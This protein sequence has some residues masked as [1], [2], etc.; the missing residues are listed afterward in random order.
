[1]KTMTNQHLLT[2]YSARQNFALCLTHTL[3]WEY[4]ASF[5]Y[6]DKDY[7]ANTMTY[8]YLSDFWKASETFISLFYVMLCFFNLFLGDRDLFGPAEQV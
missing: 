8:Y 5:N 2:V 6:Q 4:I 7:K 1:M 3:C